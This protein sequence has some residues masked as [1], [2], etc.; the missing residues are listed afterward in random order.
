[1]KLEI[2]TTN[3]QSAFGL[4]ICIIDYKGMLDEALVLSGYSDKLK[5]ILV[6][7]PMKIATNIV[8][9][10]DFEYHKVTS[11]IFYLFNY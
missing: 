4:P 5:V 7:R 2:V 1:M 3:D 10:R 9:G 8:A 6:Q 11:Q